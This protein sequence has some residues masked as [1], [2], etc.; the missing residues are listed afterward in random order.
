MMT[1]KTVDIWFKTKGSS[2]VLVNGNSSLERITPGSFFCALLIQSLRDVRPVLIL[3]HFCGLQLSP[4]SLGTEYVGA[5]TMLRSLLA[6]LVA[7]WHF[8]K[9]SCLS[10]DD[11]SEL[12]N[13]SPYYSLE[14]LWC[15]F[16]KLVHALPPQQPLFIL[17]DGIN[18]YE[19]SQLYQDTKKVIEDILSMLAETEMKPMVKVFITTAVRAMKVN[20]CFEK[21]E[22]VWIPKSFPNTSSGSAPKRFALEFQHKLA[23]LK[24][25]TEGDS[26]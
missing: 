12:K 21:S 24:Q 2:A 5:K 4:T 10:K 20:D 26:E 3:S 16:S 11:V 14:V 13:N 23:L 15:V 9:L 6:Q 1:N 25:D 19:T 22:V 8:G 18:Y 7:Q 17:I